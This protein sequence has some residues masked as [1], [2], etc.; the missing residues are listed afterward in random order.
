[1]HSGSVSLHLGGLGTLISLTL[2]PPPREIQK[3]NDCFPL[4]IFTPHLLP[5]PLVEEV[6]YV[7]FL[8]KNVINVLLNPLEVAPYFE[9]TIEKDKF[10][11]YGN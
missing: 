9:N 5:Y 2:P 6:W 1:M 11:D 7:N 8:E 10:I 3:N 4:N